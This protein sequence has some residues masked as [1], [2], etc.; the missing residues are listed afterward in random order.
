MFTG[1]AAN[2]VRAFGAMR[3]EPPGALLTDLAAAAVARSQQLSPYNV[4]SLAWGCAR[5]GAHPGDQIL[6][7]RTASTEGRP[8]SEQ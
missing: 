8:L 2:A 4:G 3:F 6:Q 5:L 7:V 1:H